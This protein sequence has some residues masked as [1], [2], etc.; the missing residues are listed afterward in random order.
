MGPAHDKNEVR[1]SMAQEAVKGVSSALA[2]QRMTGPQVTC[3]L[4]SMAN[5]DQIEKNN[6]LYEKDPAYSKATPT[7]VSADAP[8][9]SDIRSYV[10]VL[11]AD[12]SAGEMPNVLSRRVTTW[13]E[14]RNRF[15][16][17]GAFIKALKA[18]TAAATRAG[19]KPSFRVYQVRD[20]APAGTYWMFT[21]EQH[22]AGFDAVMASGPKIAGAYTP[23]DLKTFDEAFTKSVTSVSTN[24][25]S[26]NSP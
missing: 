15:G 14:Y 5:Y 1:W 25:W 4:T 9:V 24:L 22:M 20:G 3:W 18:Y 11:R 2:L 23:E 12:L 21:S 17:D 13:G 19:A 7:F 26:Y 6:M 16:M 8:F 10:A